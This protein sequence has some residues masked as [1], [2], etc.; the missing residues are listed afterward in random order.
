MKVALSINE[1]LEEISI[2]RT[3]LYE[4][5]NNGHL[6]A[7]KC[8]RKTLILRKDLEDFL[9]NLKSMTIKTGRA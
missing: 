9:G 8:G 4:S 3:K 7:L 6:K 2:G 1:V 5:I